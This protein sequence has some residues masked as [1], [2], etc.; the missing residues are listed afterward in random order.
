MSLQ[1]NSKNIIIRNSNHGINEFKKGYHPGNN[2]EK[3]EN[4]ELLTIPAR[5]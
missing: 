4:G 1:H 5:Y 2:L 3:Y